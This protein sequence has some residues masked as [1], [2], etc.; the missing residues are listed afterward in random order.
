MRRVDAVAR[1]D[2]VESEVH[3]ALQLRR[4]DLAPGVREDAHVAH[5]VRREQRGVSVDV[6]LQKRQCGDAV[7]RNDRG[8]REREDERRETNPRAELEHAR[9]RRVDRVEHAA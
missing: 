3:L 7:R 4:G 9:R 2:E 8:A 6:A 1:D 5:A